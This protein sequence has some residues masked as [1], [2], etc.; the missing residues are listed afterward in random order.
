SRERF[1]LCAAQRLM[2]ALGAYGYL[3]VEKGKRHFLD[4]IPGAVHNL[5]DV[6]EELPALS[7]L[8]ALLTLKKT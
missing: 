2:Q 7:P 5:H 8:L 3:G 6:F 4:S 1:L